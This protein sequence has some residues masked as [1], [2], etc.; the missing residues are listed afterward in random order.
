[1]MGPGERVRVVLDNTL[2]LHCSKEFSQDIVKR[3]YKNIVKATPWQYH[4]IF[5][6]GG[7]QEAIVGGFQAGY[8]SHL[9]GSMLAAE[10]F[11]AMHECQE[12]DVYKVSKR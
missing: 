9:W 2:I 7:F 5:Y 6:F 10:A 4:E 3:V 12:E 1:M 11:Q 8:Y